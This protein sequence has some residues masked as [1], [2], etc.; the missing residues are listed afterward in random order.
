MRFSPPTS[1]RIR[2]PSCEIPLSFR[3]CDRYK[4]YE[5]ERNLQF[6]TIKL[7]YHKSLYDLRNSF[8]ISFFHNQH[9][10]GF[11]FR[12]RLDLQEKILAATQTDLVD[13]A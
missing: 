2:L 7:F 1:P 4:K 13:I 5:I 8:Y 6:Q 3:P 9:R 12:L 11:V 10:F